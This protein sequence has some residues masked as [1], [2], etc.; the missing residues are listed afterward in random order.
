MVIHLQK[1]VHEL[2][3][4]SLLMPQPFALNITLNLQASTVHTLLM[5]HL[6]IWS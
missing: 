4:I 6:Y 3:K 1:L 5:N 2:T